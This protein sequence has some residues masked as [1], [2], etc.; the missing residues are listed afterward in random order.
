MPLR[1][2]VP[3]F[4]NRKIWVSC[5]TTSLSCA[6]KDNLISHPKKNLCFEWPWSTVPLI[7]NLRAIPRETFF[8][9]SDIVLLKQGEPCLDKIKKNTWRGECAQTC[10]SHWKVTRKIAQSQEKWSESLCSLFPCHSFIPGYLLRVLV[11][12]DTLHTICTAAA[13]PNITSQQQSNSLHFEFPCF[14]CSLSQTSCCL[15]WSYFCVVCRKS[16]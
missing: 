5:P 2:H 3:S 10:F 7:S 1:L 8:F 13:K 4:E 11:Q 14:C 9:F 16:S 6:Y 12:Q 15:N